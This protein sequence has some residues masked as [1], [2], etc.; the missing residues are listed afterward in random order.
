MNPSIPPN[1]IA[2]LTQFGAAGLIAWMWLTER[3]HAL[4]RERL[5]ERAHERLEEGR[6]QY[7]ILARIVEDNT[8]ALASLE[9]SQQRMVEALDRLAPDHRPDEQ[10]KRPDRR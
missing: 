8:R 6:V 10:R 1:L 3:R 7:E 5:L 4:S 9:S 2:T